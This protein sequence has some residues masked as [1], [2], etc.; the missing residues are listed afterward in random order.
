MSTTVM[1]RDLK[2][3]HAVAAAA[4]LAAST[5]N[6]ALMAQGLESQEA[7]DTIIGSEV[8]Q[9]EKRADAEPGRKSVV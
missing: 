6:M 2:W 1:I 7:I 3:L 9:E 4:F 5:P 8:K